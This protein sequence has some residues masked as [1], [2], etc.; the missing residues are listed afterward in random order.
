MLEVSN[1]KIQ[2]IDMPAVSCH[3]LHRYHFEIVLIILNL[4]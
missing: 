4:L 1:I 2:D 3:T